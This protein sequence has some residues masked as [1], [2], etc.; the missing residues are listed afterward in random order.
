M[1]LFSESIQFKKNLFVAEQCFVKLTEHNVNPIKLVEFICE[2]IDS[3]LN[4]NW[5]DPKSWFNQQSTAQAA[6]PQTSVAPDVHPEVQTA[7]QALRDLSKRSARIAAKISDPLFGRT[8]IDLLSML[9][10]PTTFGPAQPTQPAQQPPAAPSG[11]QGPMTPAFESHLINLKL[12]EISH[13]LNQLGI[14][15]KDFAE[16]YQEKGRFLSGPK[17]VEDFHDWLGSTWNGIKTA[18]QGAWTGIKQG[19]NYGKQNFYDS[20]DQ[21]AVTSSLQALNALKT[22]NLGN[23]EMMSQLNAIIIQLQ[24]YAAAAQQQPQQPQQQT[25]GPQGPVTPAFEWTK[26]RGR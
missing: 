20:Q 22:A 26:E 21:A 17:L 11:P 2:N 1:Q 6:Q 13:N 10:N 15:G 12:Q 25:P 14:S 9:N 18:A 3:D 5:F 7:I 16:W 23:P 19:W 8:L 4:E 24:K